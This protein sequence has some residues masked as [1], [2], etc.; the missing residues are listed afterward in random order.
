MIKEY[1]ILSQVYEGAE[2]E[3]TESKVRVM[4]TEL[5]ITIGKFVLTIPY[6]KHLIRIENEYGSS[7]P[8]R[9][10]MKIEKGFVPE[11]EITSQSHLKNIFLIKKRRFV[12]NC[13]DLPYKLLIEESLINSGM[14]AIARENLFEPYIRTE[15]KENSQYI[16]TEYHLQLKDKIG[17]LKAMIQFYKNIVDDL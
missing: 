5:F 13:S 4:G 15:K 14:E 8:G 10:E 2:L 3:H 1:E 16:I 6:K 11:F 17:G 9:L 7:N 12:I